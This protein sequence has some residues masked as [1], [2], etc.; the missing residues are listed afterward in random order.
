M[1]DF[2]QSA[3]GGDPLQNSQNGRFFRLNFG[4][5]KKWEIL[6]LFWPNCMAEFILVSNDTKRTLRKKIRK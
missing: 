4:S 1:A 2:D 3:K 6:V 5:F